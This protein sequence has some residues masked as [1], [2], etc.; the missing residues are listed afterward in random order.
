MKLVADEG[1]DRQIVERLRQDGHSV[2]YIAE[3]APSSSDDEVLRQAREQ[4]APLLTADK[5]FG[6]LVFRLGQVASGVVL[7]RLQ[8][9]DPDT[10]ARMVADVVRE[11]EAEMR[12]AFT[13]ISPGIVRIRPRKF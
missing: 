3:E 9:L 5:D 2:F 13:V 1:I 12:Q 6:E 10:K 4:D 8:G 7:V 11:H